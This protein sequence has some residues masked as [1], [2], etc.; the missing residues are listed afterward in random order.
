MG[1]WFFTNCSIGE[2]KS[3]EDL[4]TLKYIVTKA[5]TVE[6][7]INSTKLIILSYVKEFFKF[8]YLH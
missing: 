8:F 6:F 2:I 3:E 4:H 7:S 5:S 1:T